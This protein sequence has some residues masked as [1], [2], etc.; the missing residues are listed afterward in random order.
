[1]AK[2]HEALHACRMASSCWKQRPRVE[3]M[4]LVLSEYSTAAAAADVSRNAV[5]VAAAADDD[6]DDDARSS[7]RVVDCRCSRQHGVK[8]STDC[9]V[10]LRLTAS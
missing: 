5:V 2:M 6:D 9:D 10:S 7:S 4:V 8:L 3:T 1:M